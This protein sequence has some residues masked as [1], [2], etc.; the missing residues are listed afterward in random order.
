LVVVDCVMMKV[1]F[2]VTGDPVVNADSETTKTT[3]NTIA[4]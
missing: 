2:T 4:T 1:K 3:V